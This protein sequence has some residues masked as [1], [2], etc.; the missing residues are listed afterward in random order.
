MTNLLPRPVLTGSLSHGDWL[1]DGAT[2]TVPRSGDPPSVAAATAGPGAPWEEAVHGG[3]AAE[4][5]PPL[6]DGEESIWDLLTQPDGCGHPQDLSDL[7]TA[8][9]ASPE[10]RS[11]A[12]LRAL[13]RFRDALD[14]LPGHTPLEQPVTIAAADLMVLVR[15]LLGR[16]R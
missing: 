5:L 8:L 6:R 10:L 2:F 9:A 14:Q 3:V 16:L 13:E 1:T 4:S 12:L 7:L 11:A 15:A